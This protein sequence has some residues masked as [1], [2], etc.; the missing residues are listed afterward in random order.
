MSLKMA[1]ETIR[2]YLNERGELFITDVN[3]H[4]IAVNVA[5]FDVGG[6]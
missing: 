1:L 2:N 6:T 3:S 5:Y 4:L